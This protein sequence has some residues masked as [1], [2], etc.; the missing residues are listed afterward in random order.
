MATGICSETLTAEDGIQ[1]R[2]VVR[3][4]PRPL[5]LSIA[6]IDLTTAGLTEI[7]P[8]KHVFGVTRSNRRYL[9]AKQEWG[10]DI[11]EDDIT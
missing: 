11:A 10:H 6:E 7:T 4:T 5:V 1:V 8:V 3:Q 2:S 9:M